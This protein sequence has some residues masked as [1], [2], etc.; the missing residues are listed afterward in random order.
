MKKYTL[1]LLISCLSFP[2]HIYAHG[3]IHDRIVKTTIEIKEKPDSAYLY[4]KRGELY[5]Q[6]EEFHKSISDLETSQDLGYYSNDQQLLFAEAYAK[7]DNHSEALNY[8][9]IVLTAKP[10]S[11]PAIRLRAKINYN[12]QKY[13]ASALEYERVIQFAEE[14]IPENYI[15]TSVA[16]ETLNTDQGDENAKAVIQNGIEKLGNIISLYYRLIELSIHS[17]DYEMAIKVQNEV[18]EFSPR[19][20]AAYYKLAELQLCNNNKTDA[21]ESLASA[22]AHINMLPE[23]IKNTYFMKELIYNVKTK[24]N[25]INRN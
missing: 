8:V 1:L 25:L 5:Y 7:L 19:K 2:T 4:L 18:I 15:E 6:H 10:N 12:Q 24:E 13:H 20:E 16:W 3:D 21:I 23:R 14:P 17:N 9:G 11:V 22:K